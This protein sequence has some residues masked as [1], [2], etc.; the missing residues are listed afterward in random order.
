MS[1]VIARRMCNTGHYQFGKWWIDIHEIGDVKTPV[2]EVAEVNFVENKIGGILDA[3][4]TR[5][6]AK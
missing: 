5:D 6:E 4:K 2:R 3:E 1:P